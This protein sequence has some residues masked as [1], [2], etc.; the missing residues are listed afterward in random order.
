LYDL[1]GIAGQL[2][3]PVRWLGVFAVMG[4]RSG[5]LAR[6]AGHALIGHP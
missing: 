4:G 5:K 6:V 2:P 1:P 3:G